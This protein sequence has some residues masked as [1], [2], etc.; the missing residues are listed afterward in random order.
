LQSHLIVRL[1]NLGFIAVLVVASLPSPAEAQ[2]DFI[3][4][5]LKALIEKSG[6]YVSTSTRSAIDRE[7]RMGQSFGIGYGTA[8]SK[9]TGWKFPFSFSSYSG[10]LETNAGD[11]FGRFR[12][13]QLMSGVGYQWV[14]GKMVYGAQLGLGYSFNH[15]SFNDGAPAAF[16]STGPVAIIVSDS[17]VVRPQIKAEY[18]IH[19]KLSLR[20]QASYTYTDPNVIVETGT[21]RLTR[22]WRPHHLQLSAAVG[23]FPFRKR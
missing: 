17:F 8:G 9:Q 10:N 5:K 11:E 18:F 13:R 22:E 19:H 1:R 2:G 15:A 21:G 16:R 12:A 7:V 6:V 23:V 3:K 14:H 20:A 4:D